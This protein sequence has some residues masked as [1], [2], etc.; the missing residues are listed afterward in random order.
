MRWS[1]EK[2]SP[3]SQI[4]SPVPLR[5]TPLSYSILTKVRSRLEWK[6][7]REG[8]AWGWA[9]GWRYKKSGL[10]L[11]NWQKV[12]SKRCTVLWPNRWPTSDLSFGRQRPLKLLTTTCSELHSFPEFVVFLW[13]LFWS[14]WFD[15]RTAPFP[16]KVGVTEQGVMEITAFFCDRLLGLNRFGSQAPFKLCC[17]SF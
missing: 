9:W 12:G 14:R 4:S 8:W 11:W 7:N 13:F 15:R 3:S 1:M 2:S 17:H 6:R 16:R 5:S 10:W